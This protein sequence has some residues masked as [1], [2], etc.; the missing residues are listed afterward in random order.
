MG[1]HG[2]GH[3]HGCRGAAGPGWGGGP[4]YGADP[5]YAC[6]PRYDVGPGYGIGPAYGYEPG[7]G[8]G[9][10]R[11][12]RRGA[13]TRVTAV[14]QLGAYLASLRDEVSAVEADLAALTGEAA[15]GTDPRA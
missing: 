11:P 4:G 5:R 6:G 15:S 8:V 14:A 1:C 7:L 3:D 9:P 12:F 10:A 2:H 13:A